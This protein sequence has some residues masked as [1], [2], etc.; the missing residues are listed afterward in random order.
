MI[1]HARADY[2]DPE[3]AAAQ[4]A[5]EELYRDSA[6][7]ATARDRNEL[8]RWFNGLDLVEPGLNAV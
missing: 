3:I 6:Q 5:R 7:P 1:S 8:H 4:R 2:D